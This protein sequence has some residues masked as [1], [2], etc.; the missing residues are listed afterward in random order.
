[1]YFLVKIYDLAGHILPILRK[2]IISPECRPNPKCATPVP[3]L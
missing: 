1:M 2:S 3:S